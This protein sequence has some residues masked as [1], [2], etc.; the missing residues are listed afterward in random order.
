[1]TVTATA[2]TIAGSDS[3]AGAGIQADLKTFAALGVYGCSVISAVTAQNTQGVQAVEALNEHIVEQQLKAIF[4]D[5][6]I[7]AIKIG[8]LPNQAIMQ[9]VATQCMKAQVSIVFDPVMVSSSGTILLDPLALQT[10]KRDLIPHISLLTPN[11]SEAAVLTK[12]PVVTTQHEMLDTAKALLGLGLHSV[13]LKGGHLDGDCH[14]LFYDG[15]QTEWFSSPRIAARNT[16]GTGCTLSSAIT[17]GLAKGLPVLNAIG[18]A[19]YY[20][21]QT[22]QK[23]DELNVGKGKGSLHHFYHW[24]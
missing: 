23:A 7:H 2:L 15:T 6:D 16:H 8:M 22:I 24:W 17:A 10:L 3:S 14:D 11:L 19:K 20:I 13:L 4:D 9:V 5:I 12:R 1:M 21:T 18:E